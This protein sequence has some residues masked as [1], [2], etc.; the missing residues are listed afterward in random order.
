MVG[1]VVGVLRGPSDEKLRRQRD[2]SHWRPPHTRT[3][4]WLR[5]ALTVL[6]GLAGATI[7]AASAPVWRLA[8]PSWR[9]TVPGIPHPGTSTQSTLLF[10]VGLLLIAASRPRLRQLR[11]EEITDSRAMSHEWG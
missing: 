7:I 6:S 11:P 9:L 3:P 5:T 8:V 1:I 2:E 10:L 4:A